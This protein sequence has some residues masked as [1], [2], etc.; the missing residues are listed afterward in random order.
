MKIKTLI[1]IGV[2]LALACGFLWAMDNAHA[3]GSQSDDVTWVFP[4]ERVDGVPLAVSELAATEIEVSRD[5]VVI[6][7]EVVPAPQTSFTLARDLPPN[8]TLCYRARVEDV[9][10]LQ[11]DWTNQVCKTV[12]GKPNPPGQLEAK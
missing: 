3:A 8:Y 2:I 4:T 10:G 9:D 1:Q 7:N 6:A 12:K 11:S 5:G